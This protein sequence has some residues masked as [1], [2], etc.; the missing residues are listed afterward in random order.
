MQN[1]DFCHIR[2]TLSEKK[3]LIDF[4]GGLLDQQAHLEKQKSCRTRTDDISL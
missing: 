1:W 4:G 2:L 3:L